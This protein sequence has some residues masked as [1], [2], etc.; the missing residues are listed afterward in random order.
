VQTKVIRV[1][2]KN[3]GLRGLIF[4]AE[5]S[6]DLRYVPIAHSGFLAT[7]DGRLVSP[8]FRFPSDQISDRRLLYA[9]EE[10]DQVTTTFAL[11]AVLDA[12]QLNIIEES[13]QREPKGDAHFQLRLTSTFIRSNARLPPIVTLPYSEHQIEV[14]NGTVTAK[15]LGVLDRNVESGQDRIRLVAAPRDHG[16]ASLSDRIETPM[17]RIPFRDWIED[18]APVLGLGERFIVEIPIGANNIRDAWNQTKEAEKALAS[19]SSKG[20]FAHCREA[21]VALDAAVKRKHGNSF[22]YNER[23]TRSFKNFNHAASL[24]LH[25][26]EWKDKHGDEAKILRS[27]CEH[28]VLLTKSLCR[29]AESLLSEE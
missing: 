15:G 3:E 21:G 16:I 2:P 7:W 24:D 29:L 23:W 1:T 14:P 27:D 10:H 11:M 8:L 9:G 5:T 20:V 18:Y 13:R 25:L 4:E 22:T 26:Q 6:F 19:F 17:V 28:L 12:I